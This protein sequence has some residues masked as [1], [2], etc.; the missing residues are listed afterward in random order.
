MLFLLNLKSILLNQNHANH[1]TINKMFK[2][3]NILF[4]NFMNDNLNFLIKSTILK[5]SIL[6][7]F[8][9]NYPNLLYYNLLV[10]QNKNTMLQHHP[11]NILSLILVLPFNF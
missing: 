4:L 3:Q 5:L 9:I 11:K 1:L 6:K 10:F 7:S 2:M 8:L